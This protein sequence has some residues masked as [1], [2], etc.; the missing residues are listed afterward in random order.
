MKKY[1]CEPCGLF[2][3]EK[4]LKNSKCPVCKKDPKKEGV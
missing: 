2:L 4:H 3:A 1:I